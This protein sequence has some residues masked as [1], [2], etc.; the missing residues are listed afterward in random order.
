[1]LN[2]CQAGPLSI[3]VLTS[4][5]AKAHTLTASWMRHLLTL[6]L[7]TVTISLTERLAMPE[8]WAA[9]R[10]HAA[11]DSAPV[12][13]SL[14]IFLLSLEIFVLLFKWSHQVSCLS[15]FFANLWVSVGTARILKSFHHSDRTRWPFFSSWQSCLPWSSRKSGFNT[16]VLLGIAM[17]VA[18]NWWNFVRTEKHDTHEA[19]VQLT[20]LQIIWVIWINIRCQTNQTSQCKRDLKSCESPPQTTRRGIISK[21]SLTARRNCLV[22]PF[23]CLWCQ[24]VNLQPNP[25]CN[26]PP[27]CNIQS[28]TW[29]PAVPTNWFCCCTQRSALTV[30]HW[31][32]LI[33]HSSTG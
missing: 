18:F 25:V 2:D 14:C 23:F 6:N 33:C 16:W 17:S 21:L 7:Q 28:V 13:R 9:C 15:S 11:G 8:S 24:M 27:W 20:R 30:R 12:G 10:S 26:F 29:A 5:S 22:A 4:S 19:V 31:H 1:M 3:P 32:V